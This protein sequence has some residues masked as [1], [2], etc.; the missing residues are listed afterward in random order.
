MIV[1]ALAISVKLV[2]TLLHVRWLVTSSKLIFKFRKRE[3][4]LET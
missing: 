1:R 3:N 4:G 2:S